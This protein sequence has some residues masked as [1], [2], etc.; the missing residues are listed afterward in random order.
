MGCL[1]DPS[2]GATVPTEAMS[3]ITPTLAPDQPGPPRPLLDGL[4][5]PFSG[6]EHN[7]GVPHQD[8]LQSCV[9]LD[10]CAVCGERLEKRRWVGI[11]IK[12]H[13]LDSAGMHERCAK[14]SLAHCPHMRLGY[15]RII[16]IEP[17]EYEGNQHKLSERQLNA[18]RLMLASTSETLNLNDPWRPSDEDVPTF[19]EHH[20]AQ[21]DERLKPV[22]AA[23]AKHV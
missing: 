19:E 21:V 6:H 17:R 18:R 7:H 22:M 10:L 12:G 14:I 3:S 15:S 1:A 9:Q 23:Y 8:R 11:G 16:W 13:V 2:D 4:P 5:I 20:Y